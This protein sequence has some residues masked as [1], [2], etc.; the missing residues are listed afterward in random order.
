MEKQVKAIVP[1][2]LPAENGIRYE[3]NNTSPWESGVPCVM[4]DELEKQG[5]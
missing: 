3:L 5:L 4:Q 1:N 2:L